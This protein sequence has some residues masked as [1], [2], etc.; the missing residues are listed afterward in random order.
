MQSIYLYTSSPHYTKSK[1]SIQNVVWEEHGYSLTLIIHKDLNKKEPQEGMP[2]WKWEGN[3][4]KYQY[5][6]H[7]DYKLSETEGYHYI[8]HW[9]PLQGEKDPG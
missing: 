7:K 6:L 2:V 8:L 4:T 9:N 1:I 3:R 5:I